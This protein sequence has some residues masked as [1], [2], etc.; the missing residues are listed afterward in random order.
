M[1][2]CGH[3]ARSLD[4]GDTKFI[5]SAVRQANANALRIAL[6]QL[7][8]DPEL[9]E[10]EVVK[11]PIRGGALCIYDIAE[12]DKEKLFAKASAY[13]SGKTHGQ[14]CPP[15]R[16]RAEQLMELFSA[17]KLAAAEKALGFE[18][19][20]IDDFP[21]EVRWNRRPPQDVLDNFKVAVIGAGL[22]GLAAAIQLKRL[23]IPFI[24]LERQQGIGGTWLRNDYP[25][26]RV[27][28]SSYLYQYKFI[29]NYKWPEFYSSQKELLKY[30]NFAAETHDVADD[31][32]FNQEV[33]RAEWDEQGA[34][35]HLTVRDQEGAEKD[36]RVNAIIAATGLFNAIKTPDIA[37]LEN[38]QIPV[39]HSAEW[40]HSVPYAGKRVALVGTGSTGVQLVPGLARAAEH[41]TVFQRTPQWMMGIEGYNQPVTPGQRYLFDAM[42][43]YW[44]WFCYAVFRGAHQLQRLQDKDPAWEAAGG[45]VNEANEKLRGSLIQY[46]QGILG[47]ARPEL[48]SQMI[49][50]YAPMVRRLVVDNGF[51]QALTRP[52]VELVPGKI[53]RIEG[54]SIVSEDGGERE[55]DLIVLG[56][57]FDTTKYLWPLELKGRAGTTLQHAWSEDGPRAYLGLTMPDF[58][59]FFMAYGPSGQ[60][61]TG[62][63][64]SWGESWARYNV[65]LIA[66]MLESNFSSVEIK[67]TAFEDYNSRLDEANR[68]LLWEDE[69]RGYY[70]NEHGRSHVNIPWS[71]EDYHMMIRQP[72]LENYIFG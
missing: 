6:L 36:I 66:A 11:V 32:H 16:E 72:D 61:R 53:A 48:V 9:Q 8:D 26:C 31:Y 29:K 17:D 19:L 57:G 59:N 39:F 49:P 71:I 34:L 68:H 60:P 2:E 56:S 22:S 28:T 58:P 44:N 4:E 21:R 20:A 62:S 38:C 25:D 70:V 27:D 41:L 40:D 24:G 69:G 54:N 47:E 51:Y 12:R 52:N 55:F 33:I 5:D 3:S 46:V 42:P 14:P 45:R 64:Y 50:D 10:M 37:G 15:S 35:W 1:S 63:L 23:G 67:R 18:E 13:L 30:L 65:G 7:T 43:Y